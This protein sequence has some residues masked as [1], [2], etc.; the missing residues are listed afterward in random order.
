MRTVFSIG[1]RPSLLLATAAVCVASCAEAQPDDV[2]LQVEE[3]E[4]MNGMAMNGM[5]MNGMAMNGMA[6]NG[7]SSNGMAMNG[8]AMNGLA[9]VNGLSSTTGLMTTYGGREIVKYMVRCALPSGQ[10]LVKQDQYGTSY[11]FAGSIGV[12]PEAING[13]CDLDCQER[14]SACMLAHVNNSGQHISIWMVGPDNGIGWGSSSEYPYQ[15]GAFFGNIIANPWQGYYCAGKDMASGE[16]PGRLG[17]PMASTVY[18]DPYG[19]GTA[20]NKPGNCTVTADGYTN[21]NDPAPIAPYVA[22]HKWPHVVTVWRNFEVTQ[23]YKVCNAY[24]GK[25][26]GVT[27]GSRSDGASVEQRTFSGASGQTWQIL[28]TSYGYFKVVNV[29]SGKTLDA[30][31]S[32]M[33]QRSYTG[34]TS[35][36]FPIRYIKDQPGY[37]NLVV[38]SNTKTGLYV[39]SASDGA[40][41]QLSSTLGSAYGRWVFTAVGPVGESST[42]TTTASG[43]TNP[44]AAFC[45]N[46]TGFS[47]V[48]YQ[49]GALGTGTVCRETTQGLSGVNINNMAG[50]TFKINGVAFAADGNITALPAKVNGGYCFQATTGGNDYASFATW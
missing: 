42:S 39:D 28:Q 8:M 34:S 26:L 12:A 44:C 1:S 23:M 45:A 38:S 50:R 30:N 33:V 47:T 25:C 40:L 7:L 32:Y 6:M 35:Q 46:P 3:L 48:N 5:A 49:A 13:P 11:T 15:E 22:G 36:L 4:S 14:I 18:V 10:T 17:T 41:V 24:S 19:A 31:G 37:A 43:G 29:G 20:C 16:V 21:C 27:G 2:T 9:A